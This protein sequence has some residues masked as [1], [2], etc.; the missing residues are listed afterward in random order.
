MRDAGNMKQKMGWAAVRRWRV[1]DEV[2]DHNKQYKIF[3]ATREM[4]NK[5][6]ADFG[7]FWCFFSAENNN[8]K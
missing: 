5:V 2:A 7:I 1:R 6:P 3:L 4:T 8:N